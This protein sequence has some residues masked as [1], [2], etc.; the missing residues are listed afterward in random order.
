MSSVLHPVGP[1]PPQTYWV[2]RAA[3]LSVA[4]LVLAVVVALII[5]GTSSGS[6]VQAAPS[7]PPV[8]I[9]TTAATSSATATP[10]A[11]NTPDAKA[12]PASP[13]RSVASKPS[14]SKPSAKPPR[15]RPPAPAACPAADL[16]PTLT[17]KQRLKVRADNVFRLSL[18]NGSQQTCVA[19]VTA[20]NF[21]LK[22][23]SGKDRI[24]ST[25]DCSR[26]VKSVKKTLKAEEALE[27]SLTWNGRRSRDNCKN[28]AEIPR[29]GTYF[30]TAQL[31]GAK[32]VQLRMIL[33]G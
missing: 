13:R 16:R 27:W 12:S 22:I 28:R 33:V 19:E 6:A 30:A 21:E 29:P 5:A 18:I 1:E 25:N 4:I 2:R 14:A 20:K 3:V 24:W 11:R 9:S 26:A 32:P 23:Y 31:V 8:A 15:T 10:T 17:G 7:P